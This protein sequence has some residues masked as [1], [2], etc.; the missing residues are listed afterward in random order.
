MNR[1]I[2]ILKAAISLGLALGCGL[3]AIYV[4]E[5]PD[6]AGQKFLWLISFG[7]FGAGLLYDLARK[8]DALLPPVIAQIIGLQRRS[9]QDMLRQLSR[10]A[11]WPS[12]RWPVGWMQTISS[13]S[14]QVPIRVSRSPRP[15][16]S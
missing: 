13:S 10:I 5:P 3:W 12:M 2:V 14:D 15:M 8:R 6:A 4:F 11:A 1:K 9:Y 7:F 16:A